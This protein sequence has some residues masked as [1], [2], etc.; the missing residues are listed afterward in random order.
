MRRSAIESTAVRV[1]YAL[2]GTPKNIEVLH[3]N[4]R[5]GLEV[6][7]TRLSFS[8]GD[9]RVLMYRQPGGLIEQF[10]VSRE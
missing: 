7:T 1:R 6:T 5:G 8:K 3:A 10:F 9:L 2:V 4:E